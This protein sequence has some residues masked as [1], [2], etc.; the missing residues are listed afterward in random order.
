MI[1]ISALGPLRQLLETPVPT[2][3]IE[4]FVS[5]KFIEQITGFDVRDRAV[6]SI[7]LFVKRFDS[8]QVVIR[9]LADRVE[10]RKCIRNRQ[11]RLLNGR[12]Q[13]IATTEFHPRHEC[14]VITLQFGVRP[15]NAKQSLVRERTR[16]SNALKWRLRGRRLPVLYQCIAQRKVRLVAQ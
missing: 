4:R 12:I 14:P 11:H 9:R 5:Q 3:T 15:A 8:V 6:D 2:G 13:K 16:K 10:F 7:D 1:Q